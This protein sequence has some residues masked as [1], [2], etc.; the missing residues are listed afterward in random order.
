MSDV[1]GGGNVRLEF[2]CAAAPTDTEFCSSL[3]DLVPAIEPGPSM[4]LPDVGPPH[5]RVLGVYSD[6][7]VLQQGRYL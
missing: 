1:L 3:T 6:R 4:I 7:V 5:F 2:A